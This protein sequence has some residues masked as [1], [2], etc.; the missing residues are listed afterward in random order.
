[1]K[2]CYAVVLA[3]HHSRLFL[4]GRCFTCAT[5][6]AA[7]QYPYAMQDTSNMLTRWAI[8]LQ[9]YEFIAR[10]KPRKLHV[11]PDTLSRLFAFDRQQEAGIKP[12]LT[13]ICRNV[14]ESPALQ[15]AT[16]QRQFQVSADK[17]ET[18]QPV[19]SDR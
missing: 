14:P 1:M 19:Q 2:E 11:T 15:T 18:L 6:R 4:W 3:I 17:L 16:L 13:P 9:P 10:H 7:L 8:A 12:L 5:D